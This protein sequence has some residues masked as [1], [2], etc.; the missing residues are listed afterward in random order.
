MND[1]MLEKLLSSRKYR[2][3]CPDTVRRVWAEDRGQPTIGMRGPYFTCKMIAAANDREQGGEFTLKK[4]I[5]VKSNPAMAWIQ[6]FSD[7]EGTFSLNGRVV[8]RTSTYIPK[9]SYRAR[10]SRECVVD[11]VKAGTNEFSV[12]YVSEKGRGGAALAELF[13]RYED[14]TFELVDN[15]SIIHNS[16]K[17]VT[18]WAYIVTGTYTVDAEEDGVKEVTLTA[19]AVTYI[20]NGSVTTSEEDAELLEDYVGIQF[21]CDSESFMLKEI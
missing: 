16:Y 12:S 21:E 19:T 15:T 4:K 1:A 13:V 9:R 8:A 20:M 5:V 6:C 14:G 17:V 18:N 11:A 7:G 3:I 10:S 2:D